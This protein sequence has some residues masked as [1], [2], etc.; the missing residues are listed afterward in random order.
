MSSKNK[1]AVVGAGVVGLSCAL[2]L[3][4]KGFDVTL[5]DPADPGSGTSS[6]NAC[7]IA[8]YGCVPVN[9]PDL[10]RRLPGLMLSKDSPLS[11]NP[12]YALSQPGWMLEFLLN[13]RKHKVERI[14]RLL[15]KLLTRVY[16]GLDPLLDMAAARDLVEQRGFMHVYADQREFDAAW[17][18]NLARREQGTEFTELDRDEIRDL[19][20]N[21]K[22]PF[23]RG[24]MFDQVNQV[25]DPLALCQRYFECFQRGGGEAQLAQ[26]IQQVQPGEPGSHHDRVPCAVL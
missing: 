18:A 3:Q 11:L 7:T 16:E 22:F 14:I 17:P 8:T 19:E 23:A 10:F 20:P 4:R 25:L 15:G 9:S 6:G 5:I 12:L 2:W 13:C 1:I 26:P 21:L 24:L